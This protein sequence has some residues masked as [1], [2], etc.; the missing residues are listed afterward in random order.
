MPVR[1]PHVNLIVTDLAA[2]R[3][4]SDAKKHHGPTTRIARALEHRNVHGVRAF[5]AVLDLV[6]DLVAFGDG[7]L[8]EVVDVHED[9]LAPVIG[10]DKAKSFGVVKK[11]YGTLLHGWSRLLG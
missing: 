3:I 9:V 10:G 4:L 5:L 1:L 11:L 7:A 6:G 8:G 2:A